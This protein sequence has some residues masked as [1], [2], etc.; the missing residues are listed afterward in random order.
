LHSNNPL[1]HGA[2]QLKTGAI[3]NVCKARIL[4]T[5]KVALR[6]LPFFGAIE[7]RTP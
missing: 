7:E 6:D 3:S 2:D 1:L 4:M 5:A